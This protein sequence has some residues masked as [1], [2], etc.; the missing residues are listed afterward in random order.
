MSNT[1]L[2]LGLTVAVLFG[3]GSAL[4]WNGLFRGATDDLGQRE[5]SDRIMVVVNGGRPAVRPE[6]EAIVPRREERAPRRVA[7][8]RPPSVRPEPIR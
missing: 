8:V 4:F 3:I 5:H 1:R 2:K 7:P 6:P